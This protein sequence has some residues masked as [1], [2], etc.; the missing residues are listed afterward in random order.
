MR[1]LSPILA[2]PSLFWP[3]KPISLI[4][5]SVSVLSSPA[6]VTPLS[7]ASTQ[8]LSSP[9]RASSLLSTP[10][11]L[12]SSDASASRSERASLFSD[13]K[14]SSDASVIFPS[15]LRSITKKPSPLPTQPVSSATP[16]PF[17]SKRAFDFLMLRI[18]TPSPSRSRI[19]GESIPMVMPLKR[20]TDESPIWPARG[21][22]SPL[23]F[24]GV[25]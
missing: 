3:R 23:P 9:K 13:A 15:L 25:T 17:I 21:S 18:S 16:S 14:L 24:L 4:P 22:I 5:S 1:T 10:S 12:L 8:T 11:P 6:S 7:L 2:V 19:M 20:M